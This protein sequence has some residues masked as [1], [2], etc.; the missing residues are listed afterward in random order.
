[1]EPKRHVS[2]AQ[3][4]SPASPQATQAPS[5]QMSTSNAQVSPAQHCWSRSP[6][7]SQVPPLPL[8]AQ[9]WSGSVQQ[10][11][12]PF[13]ET[14]Q[15]PPKLQVHCPPQ[16]IS[17]PPGWH[18]CRLPWHCPSVPQQS[19]PVH[20]THAPLPSHWPHGTVEAQLVPAALFVGGEQVPLAGSQVP[21]TRHSLAAGGQTT[22]V[23]AQVPFRQASPVVQALPSS[24]A[25]PSAT[26][27][28]ERVQQ[29]P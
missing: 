4:G 17:V 3:H 29:P 5:A 26:H 24:Q 22:G 1:V 25:A 15:L 19:V 13:G 28:P 27:A 21:A 6:Q 7:L 9:I 16:Q 23:P 18:C 20:P 2:S 10:Q 11:M 8:S 14:R 12:A